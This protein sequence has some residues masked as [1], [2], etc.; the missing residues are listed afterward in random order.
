MNQADGPASPCGKFIVGNPEQLKM[1]LGGMQQS[2]NQEK[3]D[4]AIREKRISRFAA[5]VAD[6][7]TFRRVLKSYMHSAKQREDEP[8][9]IL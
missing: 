8:F 9:P 2:H 5:G 7:L 6:Y 4:V 1:S 3:S